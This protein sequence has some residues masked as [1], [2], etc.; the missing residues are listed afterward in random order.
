M[1]RTAKDGDPI[2]C[3]HPDCREAVA[4][5]IVRQSDP[6]GFRLA[7]RAHLIEMISDGENNYLFAY[8]FATPSR[9][10]ESIP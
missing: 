3:D 9:T 7:C 6:A 10:E 8:P 1:P 5:Q 4:W 2:H